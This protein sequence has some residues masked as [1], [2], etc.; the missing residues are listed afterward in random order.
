MGALFNV[1]LRAAGLDRGIKWPVWKWEIASRDDVRRQM[2]KVLHEYRGAPVSFDCQKSFVPAI[3]ILAKA[4]R[5]E[6]AR[7]DERTINEVAA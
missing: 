2:L 7:H 6:M 4:V 1:E 5:S 3:D